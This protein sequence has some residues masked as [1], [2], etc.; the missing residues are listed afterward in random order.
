MCLVITALMAL[1]TLWF[2]K[3][4]DQENRL[5][6]RTIFLCFGAAALMWVVDRFF[7][8]SEGEPFFEMTKDDALLGLTVTAFALG[9][10]GLLVAR[11]R[12]AAEAKA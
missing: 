6:S 3:A 2:W 5:H 7:A 1:A 8:I 12:L 10:W 11:D 4:R 9:L